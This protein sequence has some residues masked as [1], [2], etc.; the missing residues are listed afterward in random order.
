MFSN[1]MEKKSANLKNAIII[2]GTVYAAKRMNYVPGLG[3]PGPCDRCDLLQ[4]CENRDV[5]PCRLY[6]SGSRLAYFKKITAKT[7]ATANKQ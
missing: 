4:K 7:T 3:L 2:N 5:Q 6:N 1:N